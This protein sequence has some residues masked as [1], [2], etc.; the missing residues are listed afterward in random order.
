MLK[1]T[2]KLRAEPDLGAGDVG[3]WPMRKLAEAQN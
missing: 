2:V 1:K 3:G